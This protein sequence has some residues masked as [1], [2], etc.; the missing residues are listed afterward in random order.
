MFN[1]T[2]QL[3]LNDVLSVGRCVET[4]WLEFCVKKVSVVVTPDTDALGR[5]CS[6]SES[7]IREKETPTNRRRLFSNQQQDRY[8][9]E[10]RSSSGT[11]SIDAFPAVHATQKVHTETPAVDYEDKSIDNYA[12]KHTRKE[13]N[14]KS[15]RRRLL[16]SQ[17]ENY[18]LQVMS[19]MEETQHKQTKGITDTEHHTESAESSMLSLPQCPTW[20]DDEGSQE[21]TNVGNC[22]RDCGVRKSLPHE[23]TRR[24]SHG[25]EQC[26]SDESNIS[27]ETSQQPNLVFASTLSLS[28]WKQLG[29]VDKTSTTTN[30]CREALA[31]LV[32][33]QKL[34]DPTWF[35]AILEGTVVEETA[36][37]KKSK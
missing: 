5:T 3:Q 18:S 19:A 7:R 9:S 24:G 35:P 27:P 34:R 2:V 4:P 26:P 17:D 21:R 14:C 15:S 12:T 29:K 25:H 6:H 13:R 37:R 8:R 20:E 30:A 10:D 28:Q 32:Y 1:N 16:A 36:L 33:A 22:S 11:E 31:N 23:E